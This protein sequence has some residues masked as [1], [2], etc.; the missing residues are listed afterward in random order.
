MK[1]CFRYPYF[2][3]RHGESTSTASQLTS[4]ASQKSKDLDKVP[5]LL[6]DLDKY[7]WSLSYHYQF[8]HSMPWILNQWT[9]TI[10]Q[11]VTSAEISWSWQDVQCWVNIIS[12]LV[13][14]QLKLNSLV[15]ENMQ[16]IGPL[17][18][19]DKLFIRNDYQGWNRED[20]DEG[21]DSTM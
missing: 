17:V 20:N 6:Q 18:T 14:T 4:P 10:W 12:S 9:M 3:F 13:N 15:W 19:S 5:L 11:Y 16:D 2:Y 8:P 1:L 21:K 7:P